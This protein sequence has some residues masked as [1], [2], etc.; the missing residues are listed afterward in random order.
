MPILGK[1]YILEVLNEEIDFKFNNA[2]F[3]Y[4]NYIGR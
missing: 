4:D 3:G 1:F 2:L